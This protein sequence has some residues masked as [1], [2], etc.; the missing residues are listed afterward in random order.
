MMKLAMALDLQGCADLGEAGLVLD[1]NGV[2]PDDSP[3]GAHAD[4]VVVKDKC[5]IFYFTHP[6]RKT[7]GAATLDKDGVY[8]YSERRSPIQVAELVFRDG[9]L[10]AV[11]D[12]PFDFW[13]PDLN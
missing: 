12:E 11:R 6:G 3:T 8:P 9:T 10:A 4:V 7:H 2:R 5:Y 1:R 13:L